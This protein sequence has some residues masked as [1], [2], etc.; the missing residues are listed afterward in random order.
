MT[1]RRLRR[2]IFVLE[3]R[4]SSLLE[5]GLNTLLQ[6]IMEC[7][8]YANTISPSEVRHV[9]VKLVQAPAELHVTLAMFFSSISRGL[10]P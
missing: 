5:G 1:K 9:S 8:I 7:K 6:Y 2:Q 10:F 4:F 3:S